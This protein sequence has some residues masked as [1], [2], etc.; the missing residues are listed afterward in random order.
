MRGVTDAFFFSFFRRIDRLLTLDQH[1]VELNCE[2]QGQLLC[3]LL[4]LRN[5]ARY[6]PRRQGIRESFLED[7]RD[8][9]A[10]QLN[11]IQKKETILRMY[12]SWSFLK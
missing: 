12:R 7:V 5:E 9:E 10:R 11:K 8:L 4:L 3:E 6:L 2:S 1:E